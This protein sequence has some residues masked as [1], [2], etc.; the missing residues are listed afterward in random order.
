MPWLWSQWKYLGDVSLDTDEEHDVTAPHPL[1]D[2]VVP[3]VRGVQLHPRPDP[4]GELGRAAEPEHYHCLETRRQH[5][6]KSI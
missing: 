1:D 5:H 4:G 2:A 6:L 3:A